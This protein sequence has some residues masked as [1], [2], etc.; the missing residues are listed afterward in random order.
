MTSVSGHL[1]T[2]EFVGMYTKWHNCDPIS[3]FHAPVEKMCKAVP[4]TNQQIKK[5]LEREVIY[6]KLSYHNV[7][8]L[9]NRVYVRR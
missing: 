2:Y 1:L 4:E 3:L 5:T 6:S 9:F 8:T 7:F